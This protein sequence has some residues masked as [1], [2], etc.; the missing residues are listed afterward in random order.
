[1]E[2]V[3]EDYA[4][5]SVLSPAGWHV[6]LDQ[7]QLNGPY[8]QRPGAKDS[9]RPPFVPYFAEGRDWRDSLGDDKAL[10]APPGKD[11]GGVMHRGPLR[12]CV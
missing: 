2:T 4:A 1:M 7:I 9:P 6:D 3:A 12:L 5:T 8:A 10:L 11:R